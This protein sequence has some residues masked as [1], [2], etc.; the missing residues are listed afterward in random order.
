MIYVCFNRKVGACSPTQISLSM[1]THWNS[2]GTFKR[3]WHL[4]P[5]PREFN[6]S[7]L[8]SEKWDF[9]SQ[10]LLTRSSG[11]DPGAIRCS[12]FI[13]CLT[14]PRH[15]TMYLPTYRNLGISIYYS[16]FRIGS[17]L[18]KIT[19]RPASSHQLFLSV[20][21]PHKENQL[22]TKTQFLSLRCITSESCDLD[23]GKVC[24]YFH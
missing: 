16:L 15:N 4:R 14:Y 9:P 22:P 11:W 17:T 24:F 6:W 10:E 12:A 3:Y 19:D 2:L 20:S 1:F 7:G 18:P 21:H 23:G 8:C 5:S 13:S